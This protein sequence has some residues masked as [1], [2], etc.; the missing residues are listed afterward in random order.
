MISVGARSSLRGRKAFARHR[1]G[2]VLLA[3]GALALN[4]AGGCNAALWPLR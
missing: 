2:R 1:F 4:G 3:V